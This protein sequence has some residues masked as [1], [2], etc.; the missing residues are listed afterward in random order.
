MLAKKR[1]RERRERKGFSYLN[2]DEVCRAS[3]NQLRGQEDLF[4]SASWTSERSGRVDGPR[5]VVGVL[6][7]ER[8]KGEG[9]RAEKEET[10]DGVASSRL[11]TRESIDRRRSLLRICANQDSLLLPEKA[12]I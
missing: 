12:R 9:N 7:K 4:Y 10:E 11:V 2:V 8:K 3:E 5:W 1:R 6:E